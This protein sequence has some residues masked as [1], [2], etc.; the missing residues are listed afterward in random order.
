MKNSTSISA[1]IHIPLISALILGLVAVVIVSIIGIKDIKEEVYKSEAQNIKNY[2]NKALDEKI[3]VS[4][5]NAISVSKDTNFVK[6][7]KENNRALAIKTAQALMAEYKKETKFKNIKIHI[8]TKDVK[9]FVR[10]WRVNKFGDDLKSF[11]HTINKVK[12]SGKPLVAVELGVV[13]LTLRGLAPL[14]DGDEY[15]GSVEFMQGFNSIITSAQKDINSA[16]LILLDKKYLSISRKLKDNPKIAN[17]VIAQNLKS[18]EEH[19]FNDMKDVD[20]KLE[21][22]YFLTKDHFVTTVLVK[23]FSGDNVGLIAIGKDLGLVEQAIQQAVKTSIYQII[24][25][26]IVDIFILILII[27]IINSIVKKPLK[28][29]INLTKELSEGDGDLTKRLNIKSTDEIGEVS[30]Y[31]DLFTKKIQNLIIDTK[32]VLGDTASITEKISDN[33]SK[34][35]DIAVVQTKN[36]SESKQMTENVREELDISEELA[37]KTSEDIV[38]NKSVLEQMLNSMSVMI[39]GISTASEKEVDLAQNINSLNEQT[40]QIKEVLNMIKDIAD[41]TNLLA[42][43]A[44]IEAARAGEAGRGFAVVADNVRQLA[45]RTQKSLTE[46]DATIGVV[47]NNVQNVSGA[48]NENAKNMKILTDDTQEL[49]NL[50][51]ESKT[52]TTKT[53]EMSKKSS[54]EAVFIGHSVKSLFDKMNETMTSSLENESIAKEVSECSVEM[55]ESFKK[56]ERKL[57]EFKT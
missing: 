31:I 57:S 2:I 38:S 51:D 10:A 30:H 52:R 48:M 14:F 42:L 35:K 13:G 46:I 45:E 33:G 22:T 24:A 4:L 7:L 39:E 41:Q 43:N 18:V 37:I 21:E 5:T 8:H 11:R 9:S 1:K 53:I 16:M 32:Q 56:L 3:S 47:V 25:M 17:L 28:I 29:L 36:V 12:E 44:A 50:V 20:L 49:V 6:S 34:I 40:M 23:D 15:I 54:E 26:I 19:F 55:G 27:L